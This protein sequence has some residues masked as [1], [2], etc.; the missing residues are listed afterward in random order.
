VKRLTFDVYGRYRVHAERHGEVWL[1]LRVAP[2]G[3]RGLLGVE[4]PPELPESALAE[5]LDDLLH[6]DSGPGEAI[7]LVEA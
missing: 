2:D 6:E 7:R 3:K 5:F 4:V 1:V